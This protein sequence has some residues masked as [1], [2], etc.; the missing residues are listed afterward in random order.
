VRSVAREEK[1]GGAQTRIITQERCISVARRFREAEGTVKISTTFS[2]YRRNRCPVSFEVCFWH[3][4]EREGEGRTQGGM[5]TP[6]EDHPR[7]KQKRRSAAARDTVISFRNEAGDAREREREDRSRR[8]QG[9][10]RG[11]GP[12]RRARWP[13]FG[14]NG[15]AA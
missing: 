12:A 7:G 10:P 2:T 5:R 14:R 13:A 1:K 11:K 15:A 4:T 3:S 9:P 8:A 6:R